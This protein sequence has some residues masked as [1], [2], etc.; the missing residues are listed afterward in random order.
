MVS[1][2]KFKL[3]HKLVHG[4]KC[5]HFLTSINKN[6]AALSVVIVP[7]LFPWNKCHGKSN[8]KFLFFLVLRKDFGL[9]LRCLMREELSH[10]PTALLYI[11]P[12]ALIHKQFRM[13]QHSLMHQQLSHAPAPSPCAINSL[14]HQQLPHAPASA[15]CTSNSAM[16]QH[17]SHATASPSCISLFSNA[18]TISTHQHFHHALSTYLFISNSHALVTLW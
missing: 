16:Q 7:G 9:V 1:F 17:F 2:L 6:N 15:P 11:T 5:C 4:I 13:D 12:S 14:M 8:H 3:T 10:A 18:S